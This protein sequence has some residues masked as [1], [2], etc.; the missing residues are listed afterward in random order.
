MYNFDVV[1]I[2][3]G[4]AG[5]TASIYLSRSKI[6]HLVISG[7]MEGGQLINTSDIENYPGLFKDGKG[8]N[9][10]EFMNNMINQTLFFGSKIEKEIVCNIKKIDEKFEIICKNKKII[11]KSVIVAS[12]STPIFLGVEN[13]KKFYG[14]KGGVSVCALCDAN[15]CENEI[16]FVIGGGDSACEESLI[17]SKH[18]KKVYIV[19]RRNALRASKI[20]QDRVFNTSNIE[21]LWNS[22]VNKIVG[23]EC[24]EGIEIKKND[25]NVYYECFSVFIAIG[26]KPN[27]EFVKDLLNL[28]ENK[29]IK[30]KNNVFTSID[31]IFSAGD[32]CDPKYKQAITGCG[33]GCIAALECIHYLEK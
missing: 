16:V 13:E 9:G 24:V 8:V 22:T 17:L 19:H 12:G 32:C 10:Y 14:N 21:I 6:N 4:C 29:Y 31:G 18:C 5:L 7:D 1:I 25:E 27:T 28:D 26:S 15:M 23:D 11:S 2:G 33:M 3:S 30:T 20:M